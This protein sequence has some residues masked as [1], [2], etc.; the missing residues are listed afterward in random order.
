MKNIYFIFVI[1]ISFTL[2]SC[3]EKQHNKPKELSTE[4]SSIKYAKLFNIT[5]YKNYKKITLTNPWDS[6]KIHKEYYLVSKKTEIPDKIKNRLIVRTPIEN[7]AVLATPYIGYLNKLN[8]IHTINAIGEIQYVSNKELLKAFTSNTITE[9]GGAHN[10]N[11]ELVID[12]KPEVLFCSGSQVP[13]KHLT[14]IDEFNIPVI[15]GFDW[16]ENTPLARAEWLKFIAAFTAQEEQAAHV[17]NQIEKQYLS[18]KNRAKTSVKKPKI[19]VGQE[20]KGVWNTPSG[21]SYLGNLLQDV[22]VNY[23]WSSTKK[24]GSL[25]LSFEEIYDKQA[26]SD[27]WLNPGMINNL[28]ELTA[29]DPRLTSFKS[30]QNNQVYNYTKQGVNAYWENAGVN[31]DIVLSDLLKILHPEL[32]PDYELSYYTKVE[33]RK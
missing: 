4:K 28:E 6:T 23:Y 2:N 9:I 8:A 24:S 32:L 26:D 19:L 7:C 17:F 31:P 15:Y 16:M 18:L 10:L 33:S 29:N 1:I 12:L 3:K 30:I 11:T 25:N 27:F 22:E 5:A 13:N 20:W 14:Q 21:N